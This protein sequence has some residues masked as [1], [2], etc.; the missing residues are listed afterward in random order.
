[1]FTWKLTCERDNSCAP[2]SP[3]RPDGLPQAR[4]SASHGPPR[5]GSHPALNRGSVSRRRAV[6][7]RKAGPQ[8]Q[9][10]RPSTCVQFVKTD[11][12]RGKAAGRVLR[13]E[14]VG[15]T[16]EV[17][18]AHVAPRCHIHG[19]RAVTWEDAAVGEPGGR[20]RGL[21]MTS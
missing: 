13:R 21:W 2:I 4:S 6:L 10:L 7:T 20:Y 8:G 16:P 14:V 1:M 5:Q 3:D 18:A 11:Q 19:A 12:R 17:T 15:R 9:A